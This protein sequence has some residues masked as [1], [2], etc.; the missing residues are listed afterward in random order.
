MRLLAFHFPATV[1]WTVP[2]GG[3]FLWIQLPDGISVDEVSAA[4]AVQQ[5]LLGSGSAFF[6]VDK[7]YPALRLNFSLPPAK[8]ERGIRVLGQILQ[9]ATKTVKCLRT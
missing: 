6:P 5:V 4:A 1:T 9:S 8:T 7:G 3:T 2:E